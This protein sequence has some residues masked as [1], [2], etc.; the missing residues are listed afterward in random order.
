MTIISD[1]DHMIRTG[2]HAVDLPLMGTPGFGREEINAFF[3][4]YF[5]YRDVSCRVCRPQERVGLEDLMIGRGRDTI[6]GG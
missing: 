2:L 1:G 3:C 6:D 4:V 5:P